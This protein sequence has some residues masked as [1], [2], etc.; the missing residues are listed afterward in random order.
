MTEVEWPKSDA[1]GECPVRG[2]ER[3]HGPRMRQ[4]PKVL[5]RDMR[6]EHGPVVPILLEGDLPAWLV[7]GYREVHQV[8]SDTELFARDS[9]RWNQWD[10]IP[11]DWP[12]WPW[13][14]VE[15]SVLVSEGAEH[16][17]RAGAV[18]DALAEV[19]Q[20]ELWGK[21]ERIADE[22][23]DSFAGSGRADLVADYAERIPLLVVA[24]LCGMPE[25][26]TREL[27]T[28]LANV[29]DGAAESMHA[30]QRLRGTVELLM[31]VKRARPGP[32]VPSRLLAHP[33]GLTDEE[34]IQDLLVVMT[35]GHQPTANWIGNTLRLMLTDERFALNLS[36]GRRSVS[37]ALNEVLWEDTPSPNVLGRWA[38]RDTRLGGRQIRAGDLL[39][40]GLSGAN[41]DPQVWPERTSARTAGNHAHL[42]YG[43]GE[44]GCPF[45][46]PEIAEVIAK[47]TIEVLLDRLP[48]LLLDVDPA[49]LVWRESAWIRGLEALPAR[50]TPSYARRA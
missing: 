26:Q 6:R 34:F 40:L 49:D 8:T 22:L 47:S 39:V 37:D 7:L 12:L 24:D 1:P 27:A 50:F 15:P 17:R 33:A 2:A 25:P 29:I 36:G 46:A 18:G 28:D 11:P 41:T 21:C 13:I 20:F 19:D 3:L 9:R 14:G 5:Y 32:D 35:A 16:D 42:A 38:V 10:R 30:Y 23:I 45:P 43:Y 44:H 31:R 48:D 4:D